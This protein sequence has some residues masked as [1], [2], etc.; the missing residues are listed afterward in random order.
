[1][2]DGTDVYSYEGDKLNTFYEFYDYVYGGPT[3]STTTK[4]VNTSALD[5]STTYCTIAWLNANTTIAQFS[6]DLV[7]C[8]GNTKAYRLCFREPQNCTALHP[9]PGTAPGSLSTSK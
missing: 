9:P 2:S 3:T 5:P 4:P 8:N 7:D 6:Y 1:M